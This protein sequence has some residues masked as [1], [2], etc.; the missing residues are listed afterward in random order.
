MAY[1]ERPALNV[2]PRVWIALGISALCLLILALRLWHL[3]IIRGNF[4]RDRSENNRLRMVYVPPPR[5]LILDRNGEVLVRNRPSFNIDFVS[6]D[7]PDPEMTV[8]ALAAITAHP[9]EE[10]L[11]KLSRPGKRRMY[12]PK[13]LLRDVSRDMVARVTAQ[14]YRLPGVVV[15][16][17]PARDYIH[18]DLAAHGIGYIREISGEQLKN[19]LY[20]GYRMG[21]VI[22]QYGVE[23]KYERY[24]QGERGSQA[25]IVNA[26]GNKIGEAYSHLALPGSDVMLTIDRRL[27]EIADRALNGKKGAVV[28]MNPTNGDI[29]AMASAP[30][31][32]PSLFT[33]EVSKEAWADITDPRGNKLAN[34]VSQGVYP[35]GSVFKIF[36]ALAALAEGVVTPS[37]KFYCRGYLT[38]GKRKF[39]CHKHSGHGS[40]DLFDAMVQSCD[41][42]FY[43][44]GQRLGVDRIYQYAHDLFEFGEPT[45]LGIG[46]E[47]SGLI[48]STAWKAKYFRNPAD[49]KWYPGETLP[50]SIGQGAIT[51]TPL[52]IA[53]G[54]SAVV[55]G[56]KIIKPRLVRKVVASDGRVLEEAPSGP[57]VTRTIDIPADIVEKVKKSMVGVVLDKRGTGRKAA[58]P[59]SSGIAV[60]GKTGTAQ[61]ASKESGIKD[62]D[63]AWFAGYAPADNP[64]I[65]VAAIIENGGHGGAEAAPVVQDVLSAYFG[66]PD[67]P[68]KE[69]APPKKPV[70][71]K[72]R[73]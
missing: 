22:G 38:F 6:E 17:V 63:H 28:A 56:G 51:T 60:G 12:E 26:A 13:L 53:R 70:R 72:R 62:E 7:S 29:L 58:L 10:L 20:A 67:P 43:T 50:V 18:G 57:E 3:Q 52:Q 30:R 1:S 16:V 48:P 66:I 9:V 32:A 54:V 4:F 25:V 35:P 71:R 40:V 11:E 42:Y 24:L 68:P 61:V 49:K 31:F 15:S 59:E 14:R 39:R 23:A 37:E 73:E 33:A 69:K 2:T 41:V 5:G 27:Q 8:R 45:G 19:P 34:R 36:V 47:A 55:N 46:D 65:V 21:D 64:Q 44:V